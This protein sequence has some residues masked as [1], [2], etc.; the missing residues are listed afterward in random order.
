M[1]K[2]L[3]PLSSIIIFLPHYTTCIL[4]HVRIYTYY[5]LYKNRLEK[6][7]YTTKFYEL[8]LKKISA[9]CLIYTDWFQFL[10][11]YV[12]DVYITLCDVKH[13]I[14]LEKSPNCEQSLDTVY[15]KNANKCK[16]ATG[17]GRLLLKVINSVTITLYF[18]SS[19]LQADYIHW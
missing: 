17:I 19:W 13:K 16:H 10:Y 4:K 12:Q 2:C 7:F 15:A 9:R 3:T 18:E 8:W 14:S 5:N 11:S 1:R 6:S